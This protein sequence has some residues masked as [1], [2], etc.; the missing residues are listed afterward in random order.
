MEH[1]RTVGGVLKLRIDEIL[2][3]VITNQLNP[4]IT[5]S[6]ILRS[7]PLINTFFGVILRYSSF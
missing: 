5:I 4:L 2:G 1:K 3:T 6:S 7:T